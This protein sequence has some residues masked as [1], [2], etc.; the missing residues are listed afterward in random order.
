[1]V[2]I[3]STVI[4]TEKELYNS[5]LTSL[6]Q[7]I[8]YKKDIVDIILYP[9]YVVN[10]KVYT[11]KEIFDLFGELEIKKKLKKKHRK[12]GCDRDFFD[13]TEDIK[14]KDVI[15]NYSTNDDELVMVI[16]PKI[17]IGKKY[18]NMKPYDNKA[19]A[20]NIMEIPL[21]KSG[22]KLIPSIDL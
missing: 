11:D 3:T 21:V 22:E 1:M 16:K 18:N 13:E 4:L 19:I 15:L 14:I 12:V 9:F 17:F 5:S 10:K 7:K 2:K 20:K 8:S 6:A